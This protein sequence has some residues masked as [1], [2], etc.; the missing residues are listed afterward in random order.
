MNNSWLNYGWI[1]DDEDV[2]N[3]QTADTLRPEDLERLLK[4]KSKDPKEDGINCK[5]CKD[6]FHLSE[7]NESD[8]TFICRE[9]RIRPWRNSP[10]NND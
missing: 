3:I 5:I 1:D 4:E 6:W 8:G 10:I 7:P 2:E 9:C